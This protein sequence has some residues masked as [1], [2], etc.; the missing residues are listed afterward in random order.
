MMRFDLEFYLIK[1]IFLS[2]IGSIVNKKTSL[3]LQFIIGV[4]LSLVHTFAN[5]SDPLQMGYNEIVDTHG[6]IR[7]HYQQIYNLYLERYANNEQNYLKTSRKAFL[8]D[9]ALDP[10]PRLITRDEYT[11][12]QKGV[13]QRA[14]AIYAFLRSYYSGK[15]SFAH[16]GLIPTE[17]VDR[18]AARN[19]DIGYK[20]VLSPNTIAFLYGPD[21]IRDQAGEWRVIEDNLGF[22]GGTGDLTLAQK[23]IFESY[24]ELPQQFNPRPAK[25]FYEKLAQ[26][27]SQKAKAYNGI[28]VLY[29]IP[30]YA[31]DNE[32]RRIAEI[33]ASYGIETVTP[34]SLKRLIVKPDGVYLK[35][36]YVNASAEYEKVGFI[37]LNG[38]HAWVDPSTKASRIRNLMEEAS[39]LL[40]DKKAPP[41]IKGAVNEALVS[42]DSDSYL[43]DLQELESILKKNGYELDQEI[44]RQNRGLL[45]AIIHNKVGVNYSPGVDF[46]GDKELYIYIEE[47]IRFYLHEEPI[48]KNIETGRFAS[49]FSSQL[50]QKIFDEVFTNIESYVIKKVDGRGGDSVWVGPKL[51]P[52]E[53]LPLMTAIQENPSVYIFQKYTPL[54][55]A[56]NNIIDLR[57]IADVSKTGVIV[58]NTPWGRGIPKG[59]NGKVNIS[60]HGREIAVVVVDSVPPYH[61]MKCAKV[62]NFR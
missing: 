14:R 24:P 7:P 49:G 29:M 26:S 16:A 36:P 54:S 30:T 45:D 39:N 43:P 41:K 62:L 23:L 28:P 25:E 46:V 22:I 42:V 35:M 58:T 20:G 31:A 61:A 51:A 56:N 21:I 4:A 19:G 11:V 1:Q 50:N 38:E 5:A 44:L 10:M 13:E 6:N 34:Q 27:Y 17:L 9:N 59:G 8:G 2:S 3:I 60:D 47:L 52:S 18:I 55:F 33:F 12:L 15:N 32:D 48:L 53:K 37:V 40:R 57:M